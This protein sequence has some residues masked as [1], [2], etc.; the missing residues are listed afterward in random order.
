MTKERF[1]VAEQD[2]GCLFFFFA[3][4]VGVHVPDEDDGLS[5]LHG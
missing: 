4:R 3:R 2:C 1:V 5:P